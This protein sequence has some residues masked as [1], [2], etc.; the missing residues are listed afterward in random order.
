MHWTSKYSISLAVVH[1]LCY[2]S[3][4]GIDTLDLGVKES[5]SEFTKSMVGTGLQSTGVQVNV[6]TH[7]PLECVHICP[8]RYWI[9][10]KDP[11]YWLHQGDPEFLHLCTHY[12]GNQYSYINFL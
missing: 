11:S 8:C 1:V 9:C 3:T 7:S 12:Y 6:G 4:M 2:P 10:R 5:I